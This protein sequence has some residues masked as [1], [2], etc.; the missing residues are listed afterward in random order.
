MSDS[1]PADGERTSSA[2]PKPEPKEP[3]SPASEM[4]PRRGRF[5]M[6]GRALGLFVLLLL[7]AAGGGLIAVY[8]PWTTGIGENSAI[9]A[10]L[11]ALE[12]HVGQIAANR[13]PAA[14]AASLQEMQRN[15]AAL[16]S[17]VDANEAR[18]A[19]LEK[20]APDGSGVDAGALKARLDK[21]ASDLAQISQRLDKL[22]QAPPGQSAAPDPQLIEKVD[23]NAKALT[24]LRD[25]INAQTKAARE[26]LD[27]LSGRIAALEK[28]APPA[29]LAER[30]DSF[31]LK[32][33]VTALEARVGHLEDQNAAGMLRRAA[34][35]L[36]LADLVRATE[37][38]QPFRNQLD[39]LRALI[40][41]AP[42]IAELSRH[43]AT[44]VPTVATLAARFHRD[45]DGAIAAERT[46]HA[47]NWIER[48]WYDFV[49][50]VSVRRVG[51][52]AGN[53]TES[54][55]ARAEFALKNGDLAAAVKEVQG[56]DAPAR[57]AVAAWLKDAEA[58]LAVDRDARALTRRIVS[59]ATDMQET[60]TPQGN[61]P[62]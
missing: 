33:G 52:V 50:L 47:N 2:A 39:A 41:N 34:A 9:S 13:S 53:D 29:D 22:E 49:N 25:D 62:R 28:T 20:A 26:T 17:R 15:L 27:K 31:A 42:E 3:T 8:W 55:L 40:P 23:A 11:T 1:E 4:T 46:S 61:T 24:T 57:K 12:N 54:R 58:R 16:K 44:G 32:T 43:A 37:R 56:L 19:A 36:A 38:E 10:R 45:I 18:L 5:A 51:N 35:M 48:V 30:L 7:A 14:A 60:P 59:A 6:P 21:Y